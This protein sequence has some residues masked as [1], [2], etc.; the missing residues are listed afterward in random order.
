MTSAAEIL[1]KS[2]LTATDITGVARISPWLTPLIVYARKMGILDPQPETEPMFW[3]KRLQTT[4]A[5]VFASRMNLE[6]EWS[7]TLV[8][9]RQ[10]P[11][12]CC[13]PDAYVVTNPRRILEIK[14]V[15]V[16]NAGEWS[17]D[18]LDGSGVP[19]YCLG[20]VQWQMRVTEI[21]VAYIAVL[22]GG[23]DFRIYTIPYDSEI[24]DYLVDLGETFWFRHVLAGVPPPIEDSAAAREYLRRRFP[25]EREKLRSA[26]TEEARLLEEYGAARVEAQ[27]A[28]R[29]RDQ[30]EIELKSAIADAEGL[31]WAG[32]RLTWKRAKDREE[33]DWEALAKSQLAGLAEEEQ[34]ALRDAHRRIVE[35]SRR[36]HFA[37][38]KEAA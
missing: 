20:Q 23:N 8:F 33:T 28:D 14:T 7:D 35:G 36:I 25:R 11:W 37:S 15:D 9:S 22:I 27:A 21:K 1:R 16:F 12:Q 6:V 17:R 4:I 3:G 26:T 18:R 31:S 32:G 19:E 38:A 10:V 13:T 2:G 29:R 34:K 5:E 24:A 30:L